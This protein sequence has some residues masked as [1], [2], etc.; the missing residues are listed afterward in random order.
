MIFLQ[1]VL[2]PKQMADA[3][4]SAQPD[5]TLEQLMENAGTALA[6][7]V[8]KK[9]DELGAD[10]ILLLCGSGNNGGD[11]FV[12]AGIL[13]LSGIKTTV[14]LM[15]G[16]PKTQLAQNAFERLS[17]AVRVV[18]AN[19]LHKIGADIVV[20]CIF[21]TGFH[22]EIRDKTAAYLNEISNS[23]AY[24]IAC[25]MPSGVNS[26]SG[27]AAAA[28]V[29]CDMTVTFHTP[30]L[31]MLIYPAREFCGEIV[32]ENIGIPR[33]RDGMFSDSFK[34]YSCTDSD[35]HAMLPTR[36]AHSHKGTFGKLLL[37]CGSESYIGAAAICSR[38]AL[39]TGCGIV[40]LAAPKT[41]IQAIAGHAPE[42]VYTPLPADR[43]GFISE[44]A[45][46]KLVKL[47]EDYDAVAVGCGIGQTDGTQK[48]VEALIKN[49]GKPLL[50]DAD[51]I[52]QLAKNIDVLRDKK[53]EIVLT[54]HIGE[55]ARLAGK[56][57]AE[58]CD[59]R[60]AVCRGLSDKY[61][62]VLHSKDT[63]SLTFCDDKA[64]I[65]NYGC[66]ALAKGGS[67]DMLAGIIGSLLAQGLTP[68]NACAA[69]DYIM[70]RSAEIVCENA[71]PAAVTETDIIDSFK[72]T[73][74]MI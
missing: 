60:Y 52:N 56:T 68:Q 51:G 69:A 13:A 19:D 48:L 42:C 1:R 21:G 73:L 41:V 8:I 46:S 61:G 5:V 25:D 57:C 55:L 70:G 39:H 59:D 9:A 11:G 14:A 31:G 66:T 58:V 32:T 30:K 20:D 74:T 4:A 10:S 45:V 34:L 7:N 36:P 16:T 53:S 35:I 3:E 50:I 47:A 24:K 43:N 23:D 54:P 22:G 2:T 12:C 71:S 33:G 49:V 38:A 64:Y 65:T 40:N 29:K 63:T 62:I 26:L 18:T 15:T 28:T 44:A 37:I 6:R 67:G 17:P 72:T 27:S